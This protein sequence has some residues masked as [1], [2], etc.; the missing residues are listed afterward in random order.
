M[1]HKKNIFIKKKDENLSL[2]DFETGKCV[3]CKLKN[4]PLGRVFF[5]LQ[6]REPNYRGYSALAV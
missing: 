2:K 5:L 3:F 1:L 4:P 6:I